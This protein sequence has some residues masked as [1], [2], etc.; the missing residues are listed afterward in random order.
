MVIVVPLL[1]RAHRMPT[2]LA[3]AQ[4]T[5][6]A[7]RVLAVCTPNDTAVIR[8]VDAA[9]VERL[10]VPYD[11]TGDWARKINAG[12]RHTTE[13]L[14]FTGADDLLFHP[15]WFEAATAKLGPGVGVVGTND[16]CNPRVMRGEHAT[17]FLVTREYADKQGTLDGPGAVVVECYVHEYVD[18]EAVGTA[19]KRGSWIFAVDSVVKH[20]HPLCEESIDSDG[21]DPHYR[22][23]RRRMRQSWPLFRKR[24]RLWA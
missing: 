23:Q 19:K 5:V 17:H 9:G 11:P 10:M 1:H 4:A 20:Q 22:E 6:P 18:T 7:A 8:A 3:S 16:M 15:G 13:P 21:R 14:I 12:Y 2:M 24:Q